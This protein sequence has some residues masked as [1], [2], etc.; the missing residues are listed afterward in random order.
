MIPCAGTSRVGSCRP[1]ISLDGVT[2]GDLAGYVRREGDLQLAAGG[3][4]GDIVEGKDGINI[5]DAVIAFESEGGR[6]VR[7]V[8][9]GF[10]EV[11]N[12]RREKGGA[13]PGDELGSDRGGCWCG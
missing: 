2:K 4:G 3:A 5:I 11:V 1:D 9:V 6:D 7:A 13:S 12:W 10:L 8:R